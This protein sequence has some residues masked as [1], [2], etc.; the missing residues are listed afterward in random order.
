MEIE[1]NGVY[2]NADVHRTA[3]TLMD[4]A[5]AFSQDVECM[6]LHRSGHHKLRLLPRFSN[7]IAVAIYTQLR[8][9]LRNKEP[10]VVVSQ[11]QTTDNQ[12]FRGG[13]RMSHSFKHQPCQDE[14]SADVY[15][16]KQKKPNKR[17]LQKRRRIARRR[18]RFFRRYYQ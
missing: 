6:I 4:V 8:V 14:P 10:D 16:R 13:I 1:C 2:T 11:S 5:R 9:A 12:I 15:Y 18:R 7:E 3:R 17:Q